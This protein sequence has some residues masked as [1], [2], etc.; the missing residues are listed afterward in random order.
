MKRN[1]K[2]ILKQILGQH[3]ITVANISYPSSAAAVV[4]GGHL[5]ARSRL[6]GIDIRQCSTEFTPKSGGRNPVPW[7]CIHFIQSRW[8]RFADLWLA[9]N[10]HL[11][12]RLKK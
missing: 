7:V 1:S 5:S 4:F 3:K 12:C 11:L 9:S 10:Q 8:S 6:T 2:N